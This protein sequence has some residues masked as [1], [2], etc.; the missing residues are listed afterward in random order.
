MSE[1]SLQEVGATWPRPDPLSGIT[2]S[3]VAE[4][5]GIPSTT[6]PTLR[7]ADNPDCWAE[8]EPLGSELPDVPEFDPGLLPMSLRPLVEDI[9]ERMQVPLDFPAVAAIATLAGMTNRRAVIQPKAKDTSWFVTPK[10]W[11]GM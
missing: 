7:P 9:A 10:L 1:V 11:G 2:E 5:L 6:E 8:P 4:L 3:D